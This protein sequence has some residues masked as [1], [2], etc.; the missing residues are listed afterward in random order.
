MRTTISAI[1]LFAVAGSAFANGVIGSTGASSQEA[2]ITSTVRPDGPRQFDGALSQRFF[3][4]QG[5]SGGEF[6]SFGAL[7]FDGASIVSDLDSQ[8]GAGLWAITD[9]SLSLFQSNAFFTSNGSVDFIWVSDDSVDIETPAGATFPYVSGQFGTE[10]ALGT[11]NFVEVANGF[12]DVVD[13]S[14]AGLTDLVNDILSGGIVSV[15]ALPGTADVAATW[16]GNDD[17]S[18]GPGPI[19]T[20]NAVKIPAPGA[21]ALFGV[22][23]LVAARRRR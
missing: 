13:F 4:A 3:N 23:G 17:N 19:L 20:V 2:F 6:A 15:L 21:A 8:F 14:G 5:S 10:S 7:R 1:A 18:A 16:A 22:A 9:V 11:Y 12:E